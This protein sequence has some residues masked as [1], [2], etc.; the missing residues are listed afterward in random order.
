MPRPTPTPPHPGLIRRPTGAF[1][2]LP[3]ELLHEGWLA[4]LGPDATAV[5]VLLALAADRSGASFYGRDRMAERLGVS[6]PALDVALTRL[7]QLRVVAHKPW[8]AGSFDGVWQLL[9]LPEAAGTRAPRPR[10]GG[11]V[12]IAAVLTQLGLDR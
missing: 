9:P 12:S 2:W 4:R 3:A 6:R 8:R 11:P 5:V 7:Q 10:R 1:G